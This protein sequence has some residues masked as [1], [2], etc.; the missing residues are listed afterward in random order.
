MLEYALQSQKMLKF[1]AH[2]LA[3][4]FYLI[5]AITNH[6]L[7]AMNQPQKFKRALCYALK[8]VYITLI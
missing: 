5:F 7:Q 1:E 3:K 2:T 8:T 4:A 6:K